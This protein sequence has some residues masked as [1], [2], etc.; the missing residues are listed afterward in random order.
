[1]A[2]AASLAFVLVTVLFVGSATVGRVAEN[3]AQVH[4]ANATLGTAALA[5]ASAG[6]LAT[7]EVLA[8]AGVVPEDARDIA[9]Q[10]LDEVT[11]ALDRLG[12]DAPSE[13]QPWIGGLVES[14]RA[15]P[16]DTAQI[17]V[18]YE[19]LSVALDERIAGIEADIRRNDSAAG[20]TSAVLRLLVILVIPAS[21]IFFHRRH[22]SHQLREA[23]LRMDAQLEAER[24]LNRAKDQFIAGMSHEIRTPLT[25]IYGFSEVLM[26]LPA[27]A[28][29]D[30]GMVEDINRESADLSR[31]M[32]DF[33]TASRIDGSGPEIDPADVNV[34]FI[35][36]QLAE[37]ERRRGHDVVVIGTAPPAH[38]DSGRVRQILINLVSNAITHGRGPIRISLEAAAG[39]VRC[40]VIDHGDGVPVSM[41][42]R[43]YTRFVHPDTDVLTTGT[44]GLGTWVA[45]ELAV[46]MGGTVTHARTASTTVF[47]LILPAANPAD[48]PLPR[49][50]PA[51]AALAEVAGP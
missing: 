18:L 36:Q 12:A 7:F 17:E 1:M 5:R 3:A 37:R 6:Q 50:T 23:Q 20:R 40:S 2:G 48:R 44:I 30:R 25:A 34:A 43:L 9:G 41:L 15:R 33:I 49:R 38:A 29:L 8:G 51:A 22:T 4:W 24:E 10:E 11:A 47:T 39:T 26:D 35:A 27:S 31:M 14:F 28:P 45:R 19:E 46:A 13:L 42:D 21:A 32:D 16:V